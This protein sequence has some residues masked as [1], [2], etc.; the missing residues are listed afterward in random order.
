MHQDTIWQQPLTQPGACDHI[1]QIYQDEAF[2]TDAVCHFAAAGLRGGDAVLLIG[3]PAHWSV[4]Q[5]VLES[6]GFDVDR[7]AHAGQLTFW[8]A[9]LT[10]SRILADGMPDWLAFKNLLGGAI[11]R[12]RQQHGSVRAFGEMADLLWRDG[13]REAAVCVEEF[14]SKLIKLHGISLFCAYFMDPLDATA[15]GGPLEDVCRT[16]THL[17]PTRHYERLDSAV[18]EASSRVLDESLANMLHTLAR[19]DLPATAMPFGQAVLF[20]LRKNMP[21][22]ADRVLAQVRD[23]HVEPAPVSRDG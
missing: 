14:W 13:N 5:R 11:E 7:L 17:I 3:T 15:Y 12:K 4:I 21:L 6:E 10:L 16:H 23:L 1:A 2:L 20:W 19:I 8:D 18:N 22:T 9:E